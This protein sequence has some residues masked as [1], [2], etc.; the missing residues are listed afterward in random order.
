MTAESRP[1]NLELSPSP[2]PAVVP[3]SR[4]ATAKARLLRGVGETL[5]ALRHTPLGLL[6]LVIG[7][8]F[9]VGPRVGAVTVTLADVAIL[10]LAAQLGLQVAMRGR[11][12][13]VPL[14][15]AWAVFLIGAFG[16]LAFSQ[17]V[18]VSLVPFVEKVEM[19][20]IFYLVCNLVRTK[21]QLTALL[22][23]FSACSAL[24]AAFGLAQFLGWTEL[25]L[26]GMA[27]VGVSV[28]ARAGAFV[29][30]TLGAYFATAIT[31]L[32]AWLSLSWE[33][34]GWDVRAAGLGAAVLICFGL[35]ATLTRT[36][37]F[38]LLVALIVVV[39]GT[40][41]RVKLRLIVLGA[42]AIGILA[43]ALRGGWFDLAGEGVTDFVQQ[44]LLGLAEQNYFRNLE[45]VRV[46]KWLEALRAWQA[47]PIFG[48]GM[49]TVRFA[50][51]FGEYGLVDNHYLET[52]A[53]MGLVGALG[54]A[55][56]ALGALIYNWRA[57][58]WGLPRHRGSTLGLL[59]SHV[60]WLVGGLLWGL[61]DSGKP[62]MMYITL[63]A[64][65]VI[66]RRVYARPLKTAGPA[67]GATLALDSGTQGKE[68]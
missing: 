7:L 24:N 21:D 63:I 13:W 43:L 4:A 32:V 14:P 58:G 26:H 29:G 30:G 53:E 3:H 41:W 46:E 51:P 11:R 40:R 22:L 54:F 42:L 34:F 68:A 65:A 5:R 57:I 8:S 18:A 64:F 36:W 56:I 61:F 16:S 45:T 66:S 31:L 48:A 25:G 38:A 44:R 23:L 27:F 59:G 33:R 49:G 67:A 35:V 17:D 50:N 9:P 1:A 37:M 39:L 52:L 20:L 47:A 62:G 55:W 15:W 60:L 12:L 6:L 28:R 19:V 10:L 2:H